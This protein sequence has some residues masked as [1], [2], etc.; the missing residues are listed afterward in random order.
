MWDEQTQLAFHIVMLGEVAVGEIERLPKGHVTPQEKS[1]QVD[2]LLAITEAYRHQ[3][4]GDINAQ[5]RLVLGGQAR[6][7]QNKMLNLF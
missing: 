2:T 1:G 3:Q 6:L 4:R 5:P 7:F